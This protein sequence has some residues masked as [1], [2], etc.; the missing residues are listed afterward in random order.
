LLSRSFLLPEGYVI[1]VVVAVN[2][3]V[4][5]EPD[6]RPEVAVEETIAF[7]RNQRDRSDDARQ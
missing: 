6:E 7:D 1:L 5:I 3:F 4:A 2:Q